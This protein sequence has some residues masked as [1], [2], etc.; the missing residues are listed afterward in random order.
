MNLK[1]VETRFTL[2]FEMQKTKDIANTLKRCIR[3]F[4]KDL[5]INLII[6]KVTSKDG[7]LNIEME[8]EKIHK[9]RNR[10]LKRTW[11][12]DEMTII[13]V[14]KYTPVLQEEICK[15][16]KSLRRRFKK[17]FDL[18]FVSETMK[19]TDNLHLLILLAKR[20]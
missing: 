9:I 6:R 10:V 2:R 18:E 5:K 16:K 17:N 3:N 20:K 11:I 7:L 12:P 19:E 1:N 13:K 15:I 8:G 4:R 14:L